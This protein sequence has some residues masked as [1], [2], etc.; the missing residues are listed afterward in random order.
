M[1]DQTVRLSLDGK[2]WGRINVLRP[3]PQEGNPWGVFACLKGT[4][5]GDLMA[6]V[7]GADFSHAT[8][9]N[10]YPMLKQLG[11]A[12]AA[13]A[14]KL[15]LEFRLCVQAQ[16]R[17]CLMATPKCIPGP[18]LP[19]CYEAPNLESQASY[20]ASAIAVAWKEGYYAIVVEG[21]EFV[22]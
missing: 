4:I 19:D 17:S 21:G 16:N 7:D 9:G 14:K 15:P 2:E 5:W 6:V 12:P 11:P 10:P 1:L 3:I 20:V 18:K 13:L 22:I 8:H